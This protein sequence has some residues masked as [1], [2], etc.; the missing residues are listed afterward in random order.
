MIDPTSMSRALRGFSCPRCYAVSDQPPCST[1][2]FY[3]GENGNNPGPLNEAPVTHSPGEGWEYKR[4]PGYF[5][6]FVIGPLWLLL[7]IFPFDIKKDQVGSTLRVIIII[8]IPVK[9]LTSAF[10]LIKWWKWHNIGA[11]P[12]SSEVK[13]LCCNKCECCFCC[14]LE[15]DYYYWEKTGTG[16]KGLCSEVIR[17]EQTRPSNRYQ[18]TCLDRYD[19]W[20]ILIVYIAAP[21]IINTS[22]HIKYFSG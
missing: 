22:W 12:T 10:I 16:W 19:D 5:Y 17:D 18:N 1:C 3:F 13:I 4:G 9:I 21:I 8:L 11:F 7:T 15:G 14:D 6:F 2:G 20:L